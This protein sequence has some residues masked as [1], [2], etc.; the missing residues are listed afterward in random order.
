MC[1]ARTSKAAWP[2]GAPARPTCSL[3]LPRI[4]MIRIGKRRCCCW[5]REGGEAQWSP[6]RGGADANAES[7]S[8]LV[9]GCLEG[10]GLASP[11]LRGRWAGFPGRERGPVACR[12]G[13]RDPVSLKGFRIRPP[14]SCARVS[15]IY[16]RA[17]VPRTSHSVLC[18]RRAREE[19]G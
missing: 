10:A 16:V 17:D 13:R 12:V 9:R 4:V 19:R 2:A 11:D 18:F 1:V 3:M 14:L 6:R 15:R 5:R 7:R 8:R